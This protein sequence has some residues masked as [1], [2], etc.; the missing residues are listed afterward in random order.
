MSFVITYLYEMALP[1]RNLLLLKSNLIP[2]RM[3]FNIYR[4]FGGSLKFSSAKGH[5]KQKN[6]NTGAYQTVNEI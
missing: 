3:F 2:P 1:V 5:R 4:F 6:L